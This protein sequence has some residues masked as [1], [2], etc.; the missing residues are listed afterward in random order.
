VPLVVDLLGDDS[1][2]SGS[3]TDAQLE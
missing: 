2:E 1:A 3:G